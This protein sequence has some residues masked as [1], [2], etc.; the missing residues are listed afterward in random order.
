MYNGYPGYITLKWFRGVWLF[1]S[2]NG[3]LLPA[4][5][6]GSVIRCIFL[7][8]CILLTAVSAQSQN[9]KELESKRKQLLEEIKTADRL[10]RA[11][12]RNRKANLNRLITLQNQIKKREELVRTLR[13]EQALV[14]SIIN[15]TANVVTA[16]QEDLTNLETEYGEIARQAFRQKRTT[17]KWYF[18][19]SSKSLNQAFKRWQY[20]RQYE[21]F[22]DKQ[23]TLML[24]TKETLGDKIDLL[25]V[26]RAEKEELI[27]TTELQSAI[28]KKEKKDK[29]KIVVALQKDEKNLRRQLDAKR[30]SHEQLNNAIEDVIHTEVAASRRKART[31]DALNKPPSSGA[32]SEPAINLSRN[33]INN[34]GKLPW[35]VKKGVITGHYGKQ[36]HPTLKKIQITNNGIDIQTTAGNNVYTVFEGEV[37]GVQYIPGNHYMVIVK[38][39]QYYTVYANLEVVAVSKGDRLGTGEMI[40]KLFVNNETNTSE[41]HFE[42]WQNKRRMNPVRWIR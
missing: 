30:K 3:S 18:L 22:R 32:A 5:R 14:D 7:V 33:F 2:E 23:A 41:I 15:R 13:A 29:N 4:G 12:T 10:L 37:A 38:H 31:P 9:R 25:E 35:P 16:L 28:L 39:G 19:L 1:L 42:V 21:A 26:Q 11:T 8:G 27:N 17:N 36:P 40:G 20:L 24:A 34:K 6:R